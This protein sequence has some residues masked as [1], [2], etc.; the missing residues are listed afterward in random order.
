MKRS[1]AALVIGMAA[2]VGVGSLSLGVAPAAALPMQQMYQGC[3]ANGG[4]W[5]FL[6]MGHRMCTFYYD[7]GCFY[8]TILTLTATSQ[9]YP[10]SASSARVVYDATRVSGRLSSVRHSLE[11]EPVSGPTA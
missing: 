2:A 8:G 1:R 10:A 4:D 6:D 5:W 9:R 11:S 3:I 7:D